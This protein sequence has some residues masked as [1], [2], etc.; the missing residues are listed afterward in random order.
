MVIDAAT[1]G[2]TGDYTLN[3]GFTEA[4]FEHDMASSTGADGH[5]SATGADE[6]PSA[7]HN[8]ANRQV[9][10]GFV[11]QAAAG[12]D[13]PPAAP[14]GL[15]ATPDNNMVS[16][17]WDD[18]N[19]VDLDGYNVYR[20]ITSGVYT[21]PLNG[22]LLSNSDYTDNSAVN[23]TT[24]YYVVTAVDAALHESGYSNEASTTPDLYQNCTEVQAGGHGFVVGRVSPF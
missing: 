14:T 4:P 24:Y 21:I 20:S 1:C 19:E 11:V 13:P 15:V 3:N 9:I 10:I 6:T 7:T 12:V 17:D 5:K 2:N 22:S 8:N 23:G 16:L 18:N